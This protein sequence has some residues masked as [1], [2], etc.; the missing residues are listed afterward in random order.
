MML[1]WGMDTDV[2]MLRQLCRLSMAIPAHQP[3]N[4]S[5]LL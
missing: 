3:I 5:L 1:R 2:K 4:P